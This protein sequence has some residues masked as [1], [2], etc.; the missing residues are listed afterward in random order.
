MTAKLREL[1]LSSVSSLIESRCSLARNNQ[2]KNISF[3]L[4]FVEHLSADAK[5][6]LSL[7]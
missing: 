6:E 5:N 3:I 4:D 7:L 1:D 2:L